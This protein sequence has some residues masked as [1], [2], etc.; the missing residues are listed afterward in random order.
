MIIIFQ[1]GNPCT[2]SYSPWYWWTRY[3]LEKSKFWNLTKLLSPESWF[4]TFLTFILIVVT[5]KFASVI[6]TKI[7]LNV[8]S[9]EV[10]LIPFRCLN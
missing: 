10:A 8:G 2:N 4:W 6:G 1:V 9:E 3:P 7:E 5:L